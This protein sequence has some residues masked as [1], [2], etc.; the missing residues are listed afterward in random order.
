VATRVRRVIPYDSGAWMITDPES[1]LP[2]S[3]ITVNSTPH[4]H[5]AYTRAELIDAPDDVNNYH[6]MI[7]S[8]ASAAALSLTTGGDL[9]R[10]HRYR[11][12]AAPSGQRDELRLLAR[13]AGSTWA[14]GC[15]GRADDVP[16]F[17]AEEVRYVAAISEYLGAGVRRALADRSEPTT[18]RAP[19]M[20]VLGPDG[21]VEAATGEADRWL[22]KLGAP[23]PGMLPVPIAVVAMQA[24]ANAATAT[25]LRAARVRIPVPGG[26]LLV[27][28]DVLKGADGTGGR[29][30]VVIEPAD[31]TELVPLLLA[32][33]GLTGREREVAELLVAGLGTDE[34]ADRLHISRHTLRDHVKSIFGKVGVSSRPE[35][36]AA[37]SL[38]A[39]AA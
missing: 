9:N 13:S 24:Q 38:E 21:N 18:L 7:R 29:V 15:V 2:T 23:F 3:I 28:A 31:R 16:D 10:S 36:T 19:G 34:I 20:L 32:L 17:T 22:E 12:V 4:I 5:K 37:L 25:S 30:A 6:E 8:G 33:H 11:T 1:M 27:H 26:W 35:L 39:L 14:I